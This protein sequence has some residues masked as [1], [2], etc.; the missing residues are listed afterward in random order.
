LSL[1]SLS[2]MAE[3]LDRSAKK[4]KKVVTPRKTETNSMMGEVK[5]QQQHSTRSVRRDKKSKSAP[6]KDNKRSK[7]RA[8]EKKTTEAG[9]RPEYATL[10]PDYPSS[11]QMNYLRQYVREVLDK[12]VAGLLEE[13]ETVKKYNINPMQNVAHKANP[14]KNRYN[15][16]LCIDPTRVILQGDNDYIHANHVKGEPFINDF[17]C[18]QGPLE[19]TVDDF[20]KM[21]AQ[22]NVGYVIMLCD[23][24]ELGKKKCAKYIPEKVDEEKTY[25][26]IKVKLLECNSI[27]PQFISSN[28]L[29]EA[30]GTKSRIIFHY[31]WREWPDHGVPVTTNAALRALSTIRGS[32]F[33]AIVHCSAGVGRTGTLVSVEWALQ[34]IMKGDKVDMKKMLKE[35]RNQRAHAIQMNMQYV[36]VAQC[37]L[38]LWTKVDK[39]KLD[40][41]LSNED[42]FI[43]F[44]T[45]MKAANPA[46][47]NPV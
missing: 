4:K 43:N 17:I 16:I 18:A 46:A 42:V 39:E 11:S 1:S 3:R 5:P 44:T 47:Y 34:T 25:G 14:K 37:I 38:R 24:M 12:G 35:M 6:G 33:T 9:R 28:L 13:Y 10:N 27:D 30:P 15:D 21:I 2:T 32:T 31:Q 40:P 22:E 29:M 26:E 23:L 36:Y 19:S 8:T 20:W 41:Y 7:N 45:N